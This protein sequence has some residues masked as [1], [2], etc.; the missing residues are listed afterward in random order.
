MI[1][2]LC[3][4]DV[5]KMDVDVLVREGTNVVLVKVKAEVC[6][7]CG[8]KLYGPEEVMLFD[9]IRKK[10]RKGMTGEFREVGRF[11]ELAA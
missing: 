1:C 11:Y 3:R 4:G 7:Q 5:K 2:P 9:D 6:L 10:L 8:E